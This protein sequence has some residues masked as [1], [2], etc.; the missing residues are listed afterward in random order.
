MNK[1][2]RLFIALTSS[3]ILF[4][5][6]NDN[7]TTKQE[8]IKVP[9]IKAIK[10]D[11][12]IYNE[13]VGNMYGKKDIPIRA[14]V[15]GFLESMHF[16]EGSK[17]KKGQLLYT[18]DPRSLESAVNAQRSKVAEAKTYLAK[19]KADS[20]RIKPLAESNAVSKSELDAAQANY[21]AAIASLEAAKANLNSS[22]IDLSYTKI[23]SPISG[24][25]G[26]TNA[27]VGE[28][29]G[30]NPNPVI[31][32]TVS[33][34][35]TVKVKFFV[36]ESQYIKLAKQLIQDKNDSVK[37]NTTKE[38]VELEL[39]DGEIYK[40]RG[41]IDFIDRNINESTGSIMVQASFPNPDGLLRS[42]LYSKVKV[43]TGVV[44]NAIV[45]PQRCIME[46]QGRLS[47]YIVNDSNK[48]VNKS[49]SVAYKTGDIAAVSKG[50]QEGDLVVIDALQKVK[51]GM[52]AEP[53]DTV[54]QS[55]V[56]SEIKFSK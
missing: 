5:S 14:R 22:N 37:I 6:C 4:I 1:L 35:D 33:E 2:F 47:V 16:K 53:V 10:Q 20:N 8:T 41:K 3:S 52:P 38:T 11:I 29:V 24:V 18:I 55:K 39:A 27:Q 44:R 31:L 21:E 42:G 56:F 48:I 46:M 49:V 13:Y 50:L 40:H 36:P 9:V 45:I 25:I 32:N 17:V 34:T 15:E 54:F 30:K 23:K 26:K 51:N 28:F 7:K 43:K 19:A 12:P